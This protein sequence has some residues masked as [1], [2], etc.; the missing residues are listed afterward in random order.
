MA[1]NDYFFRRS[2]AWRQ[3]GTELPEGATLTDAQALA[4]HNFDVELQTITCGGRPIETGHVATVRTDT[5]TALGIVKE[6]Y[7]II[8]PNDMYDVIRPV[9]GESAAYLDCGGTLGK[10]RLIWI[11]AKFPQEMYV[12][13]VQDDVINWYLLVLNSFDRTRKLT[14]R[15]TPV[16]LCC[17]NLMQ[18]AL[19]GPSAFEIK[20]SHRPGAK[21]QLAL[22][23]K[24]IGLITNHKEYLMQVSGKMTSVQMSVRAVT[25]FLKRLLP[26]KPE[27]ENKEPAAATIKKRN[28]IELLFDA[29]SNNN[30]EGM[31]GTAWALYNAVIEWADHERVVKDGS[32][33]LEQLWFG[34]KAELKARAA[35]LL[36]KQL[37]GGDDEGD[38]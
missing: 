36:L 8:Q 15:S 4:G 38:Q 9:C 34:G 1:D 11:M 2:P 27:A 23:H 18:Q 30:L 37:K 24:S 20:I 25:S 5:Q 19:T 33:P 29:G 28:R 3:K 31:R 14:I 21:E 26:S 35:K 32:D 10:G 6:S 22:A 12:P 17:M 7:T 16:R 13:G